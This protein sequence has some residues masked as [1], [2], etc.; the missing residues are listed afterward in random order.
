MSSWLE[1]LV[2]IAVALYIVDW[3]AELIQ[4]MWRE[5]R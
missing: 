4:V 1:I 3:V 5:W 2:G